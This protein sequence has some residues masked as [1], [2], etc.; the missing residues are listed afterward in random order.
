LRVRL[1]E[2]VGL[3]GTHWRI[4]CNVLCNAAAI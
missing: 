3:V 4:L 2:T 1:S